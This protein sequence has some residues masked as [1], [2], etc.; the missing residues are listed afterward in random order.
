MASQGSEKASPKRNLHWV[1]RDEYEFVSQRSKWKGRRRPGRGSELFNG[2]AAEETRAPGE[3]RG[4]VGV[5]LQDEAVPGHTEPPKPG[6][7]ASGSQG[8]ALEGGGT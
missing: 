5:G 2:M 1:L 4:T 7:W 8:R 3:V 6:S